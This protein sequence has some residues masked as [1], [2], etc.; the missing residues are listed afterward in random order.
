ML[1]VAGADAESKNKWGDTPLE[2]ARSKRYCGPYHPVVD[3]LR[4]MSP[5]DTVH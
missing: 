3:Y 1:V 2:I 4:S 5:A